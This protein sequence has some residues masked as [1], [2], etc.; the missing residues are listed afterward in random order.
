MKLMSAHINDLQTLYVANLK[1][2][3]DLEQQLVDKGLP[4]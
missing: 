4:A 1:K 3:L 2:A